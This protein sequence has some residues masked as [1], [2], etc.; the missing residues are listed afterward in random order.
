MIQLKRFE[1]ETFSNKRY[2]GGKEVDKK[3]ISVGLLNV[4]SKPLT[5]DL[6][7]TLDLFSEGLAVIETRPTEKRRE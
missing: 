4:P 3:N 1:N 5:L 6:M 7:E 2:V